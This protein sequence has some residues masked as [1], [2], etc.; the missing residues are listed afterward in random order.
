MDL[1]ALLTHFF[2]TADLETL[3]A[4]TISNGSDRV[5]IAFATEQ[6]AGRRFA[7]WAVLA[8]LG[9]APD[10]RDAFETA[11]ERQAASAYAAALRSVDE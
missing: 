11:R 8:A 7:L 1:D 6:E 2:G 3:D 5:R 4:H 10:P 9:D